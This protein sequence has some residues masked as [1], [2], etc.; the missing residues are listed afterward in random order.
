MN[1]N[2]QRRIIWLI[3]LLLIV[4]A[5]IYGFQPQPRL[6]DVAEVARAIADQCGR[7]R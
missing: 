1:L 4:A 6:V 2:W 3:V 7:G 5:L